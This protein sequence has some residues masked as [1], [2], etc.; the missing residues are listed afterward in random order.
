MVI[1]GFAF[2]AGFGIIWHIWWLAVVGFLG[3]VTTI[4]VR[5]TDEET[6]RTITA[7][8]IKELEAAA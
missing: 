6:Q 2:L 3:V 5:S 4:I 1:A 7:S 8:E